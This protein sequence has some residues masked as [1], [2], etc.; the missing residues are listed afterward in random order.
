M[1][2]ESVFWLGLMIVLLVIELATMGLTTIWFA[3]G[4]LTAFI[5][6]MAGAQLWLQIVLFFGISILL[7]IFTRPFAVHYINKNPART[8]ADSLIGKT[9][10]VTEEISNLES[11]GQ[12]QIQGQIWTARSAKEEATMKPGEK[13]VVEEIRGVKLIVRRE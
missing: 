4:S 12:V 10:I 9:G 7:L 5:A 11:K 13:V 8:N 3:G 1:E 2:A 6:S